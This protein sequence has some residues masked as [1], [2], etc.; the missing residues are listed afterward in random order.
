[1][2]VRADED[3]Q[4]YFRDMA[5]WNPPPAE[6]LEA[7][8]NQHATPAHAIQQNL[9]LMPQAATHEPMLHPSSAPAANKVNLRV[10]SIPYTTRQCG[11]VCLPFFFWSFTN[12]LTW[13]LSLGRGD[14][15]YNKPSALG[16]YHV[17]IGQIHTQADVHFSF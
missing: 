3:R 10:C 7:A 16:F 4:R 15:D 8:F 14:K 6:G 17:F 2:Q 1:M 9:L 11:V 12:T 5:D 13:F